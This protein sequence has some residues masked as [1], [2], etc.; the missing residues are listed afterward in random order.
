[1]RSLFLKI[2]LS[3][4]LAE[5]LFIVLAILVTLAFRPARGSWEGLRARALNESVQAYQRGGEHEAR[6]YLEDLE[7]S[8]HIRAFLYDELGSEVSRRAAPE[9]IE[10]AG[11]GKPARPRAFPWNFLPNRVLAQAIT[12]GDGHRYMLVI[13]LPPGPRIFFGPHG[14]PG[15]GFLIALISS[16]LV[17]YVLARYLTGPIV[18]LRSATQRL[19][20]GDLSARAGGLPVRRRDEMAG[21]V[22]D[23][24][25]MASRLEALVNAQSRLLNDV[26]HELRSPLARLSVALGLAR[27]RTGPEA[28]S[29]LDRIEREAERLNEMIGRLLTIARL[30]SGEDGGQKQPLHLEELVREISTDA[31]FEAQS[32]NCRVKCVVEENC[33]VV[34]SE[35]LL[36]SAIENVI[37][38][39]TRYTG[40]G[41]EVKVLLEKAKGTGEGTAILRVLDSG[42]GVP[43]EALDKLFRPFY[44][45][46]DARNPQTGGAG[47]GLS[48]TDRT[49]RLHGGSVI[50]SNRPEGG[51][52]VEIRLPLAPSPVHDSVEIPVPVSVNGGE[53]H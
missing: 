20:A 43:S 1:M 50:A 6:Q 16:G 39:A 8:Q 23:F 2:F 21:L 24:D 25:A 49:V 27:Q 52:A 28:Q 32:R 51:L 33:I 10:L 42:P 47:L 13:E 9:W 41:T 15:A 22:R 40:E 29:T 12:A 14:F 44:R 37:R 48:I 35:S 3:F 5:A 30:E 18:R 11:R 31:D 4:W 34:G 53:V 17:C 26:S 36:H 38:N 7:Q 45:L 19:A 46:D